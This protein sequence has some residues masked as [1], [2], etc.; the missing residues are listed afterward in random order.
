MVDPREAALAHFGIKGMKWGVR[1][2]QYRNYQD[3][4]HSES[5]GARKTSVKT[6]SGET[7]AVVKEKAGPLAM[8]VGKLTKTE[9]PDYVSAMA[10]H[11]SSGKK[12]GSFQIWK[13]SPSVV[14]GEWLV[15]NESA[16]GRGY[17]KAAIEGLIKASKK[18]PKIKEIRLQV[19]KNA[20]PAKHIYSSLGFKKD[21]TYPGADVGPFGI[22]EDWV[23]KV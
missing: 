8:L 16:Q 1:K 6:K 3:R 13:E 18:D 2:E 7:I 22:L 11:D 15:I 17:S 21:F 12:V 4:I 10:I 23:R 20:A 9:P 5:P 14:R 19:P